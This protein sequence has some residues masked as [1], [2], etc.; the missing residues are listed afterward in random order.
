MDSVLVPTGF[1]TTLKNFVLVKK[2][3]GE[4]NRSTEE[5]WGGGLQLCLDAP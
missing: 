1:L 3:I 4:G 5:A 2:Y